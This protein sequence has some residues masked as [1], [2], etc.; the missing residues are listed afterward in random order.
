MIALNQVDTLKHTPCIL[1]NVNSKRFRSLSAKASSCQRLKAFYRHSVGNTNLVFLF[2][3]PPVLRCAALCQ[4]IESIASTR[5]SDQYAASFTPFDRRVSEPGENRLI[6][7]I[8]AASRSI[9]F[10]KTFSLPAI[11]SLFCFFICELDES[12]FKAGGKE[13]VKKTSIV[14]RMKVST[15]RASLPD[16]LERGRKE[17]GKRPRLGFSSLVFFWRFSKQRWDQHIG[18]NIGDNCRLTA[19]WPLSVRHR[20][21]YSVDVY[22]FTKLL[23]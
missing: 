3:I 4:A 17:E 8:S 9:R 11:R 7:S 20:A 18:Q 2:G 1:H 23:A 10:R 21:E 13:S 15:S 22:R 16:V 5:P 14:R 6:K 19:W 12:H